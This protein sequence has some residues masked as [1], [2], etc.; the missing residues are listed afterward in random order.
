M[1]VVFYLN[2][3]ARSPNRRQ[4]TPA[5]PYLSQVVLLYNLYLFPLVR[6]I[7]TLETELESLKHKDLLHLNLR[8]QNHQPRELSSSRA[9]N[10]VRPK[11][12]RSPT[13]SGFFLPGQILFRLLALSILFRRRKTTTPHR[14]KSARRFRLTPRNGVDDVCGCS[15]RSPSS[16]A[17]P[18]RRPPSARRPGA[19]VSLHGP[20][21][22]L[23]QLLPPASPPRSA[24]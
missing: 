2:P 6:R 9:F 4:R 3:S 7:P 16:A 1:H 11:P 14:K 24:C 22:V 18:F 19:S 20:A 8:K 13:P 5:D 23:Q 17:F 21:S 15:N 12:P 10:L